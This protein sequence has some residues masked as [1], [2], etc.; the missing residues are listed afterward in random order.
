MTT[1]L[2]PSMILAVMIHT[3]ANKIWFRQLNLLSELQKKLSSKIVSLSGL[4]NDTKCKAGEP[5]AVRLN[6]KSKISTY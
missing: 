1:G 5:F 2:Q 3:S 6:P 4:Q